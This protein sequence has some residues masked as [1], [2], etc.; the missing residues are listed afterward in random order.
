MEKFL[1]HGFYY[2]FTGSVFQSKYEGSDQVWRNTAFNSNYVANFLGGK[3]FKLNQKGSFSIDT[4]MA[5]AGGQRYTA[6]DIP[7]SQAA[8]Y[9]IYKTNEAY[10]LQNDPYMR[11]DLKFSYTSNG[12]KT[13]QKWYLDL[14]N[15]T[16]R[17]NIYIRTLNPQTGNISEI[18]QIGFFPNINY[19]ITF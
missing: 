6:F 19:Q 17:K 9:V 13:T 7:A 1:T 8:G 2:L 11:W 10:A 18:N 14:Q 5:I 12:K 16:N 15:L 4:K 3:E